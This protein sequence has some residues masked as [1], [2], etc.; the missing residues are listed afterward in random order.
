VGDNAVLEWLESSRYH[1]ALDVADLGG[2]TLQQISEQLGVTRERVRQVEDRALR[3]LLLTVP[4]GV[5]DFLGLDVADVEAR[6]ERTA[7]GERVS[8]Y[9]HAV[10]GSGGLRPA[11]ERRI[12]P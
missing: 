9:R 7:R 8:S 4:A 5:A 3:R 6:R 12:A 10:D 11:R 1:C 2:R